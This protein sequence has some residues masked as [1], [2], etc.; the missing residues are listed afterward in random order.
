MATLMGEC[1]G[2]KAAKGSA[3]GVA[4][5][6]FTEDSFG[7]GHAALRGMD[8]GQVFVKQRMVGVARELRFDEALEFGVPRGV[9]EKRAKEF[10]VDGLVARQ[11]RELE[12]HSF[13]LLEVIGA[14]VLPGKATQNAGIVGA[15]R[16]EQAEGVGSVVRSSVVFAVLCEDEQGAHGFRVVVNGIPKVGE[17][18]LGVAAGYMEVC[19]E[20]EQR[21]MRR[22]TVQDF[23][24]QVGG[25]LRAAPHGEAFQ[26]AQCVA[27]AGKGRHR[28]GGHGKW[29]E[30]LLLAELVGSCLLDRSLS[31]DATLISQDQSGN[32]SSRRVTMKFLKDRVRSKNCRH[33]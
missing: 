16:A 24:E 1:D 28:G 23:V 8:H 3:V 13:G 27:R 21:D 12:E 6:S 22:P 17:A 25:A 31:G 2:K 18:E 7:I 15:Q 26:E 30:N 32:G 11:G 29:L 5:Q 10:C 14:V 9:A 4:A 19:C 33:P 20:M